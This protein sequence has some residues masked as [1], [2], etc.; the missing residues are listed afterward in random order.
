MKAIHVARYGR[1][2]KLIDLSLPHLEKNNFLIK[3]KYAPIN[4][5]D[6]NFFQGFYGIRK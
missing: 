2:P 5:S 4:P 6:I 3:M 1:F